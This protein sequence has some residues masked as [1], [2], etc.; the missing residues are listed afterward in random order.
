MDT[1]DLCA[2]EVAAEQVK[3]AVKREVSIPESEKTLFTHW[4]M[5]QVLTGL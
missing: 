4:A 1:P 3:L 5:E 2:D